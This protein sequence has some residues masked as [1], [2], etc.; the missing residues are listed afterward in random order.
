MGFKST[1]NLEIL[2]G[3]QYYCNGRCWKPLPATLK[4]SSQCP[5]LWMPS[6][7]HVL[8]RHDEAKSSI[9]LL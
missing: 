7:L 2:N 1:L 8:M 5:P 3:C 4:D 6:K 9:A